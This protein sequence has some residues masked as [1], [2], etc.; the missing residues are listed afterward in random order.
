MPA[1]DSA[2]RDRGRL[3][4]SRLDADTNPGA[5]ALH[6]E[7]WCQATAEKALVLAD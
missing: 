6:A 2:G 7:P 1:L 3:N 5:R 4:A